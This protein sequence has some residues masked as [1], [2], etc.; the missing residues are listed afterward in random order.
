MSPDE[1]NSDHN[2]DQGSNYSRGLKKQRT[3]TL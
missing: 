3:R 1:A 2:P